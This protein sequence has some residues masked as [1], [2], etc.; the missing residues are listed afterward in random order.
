MNLKAVLIANRGEIAVRI[1]RACRQLGLKAVAVFSQADAGAYWTRLADEAVEIG[2]AA[3]RASYLNIARLIEVAEQVQADAVH[4]GY[5]LL[6]ESPEF[7]EAVRESG[8]VFVGPTP[9][10]I[11]QMGDKVR[12][13]QAAQAA[14]LPVLPGTP[15]AVTAAEARVMAPDIGFP[16][17]VKASFGGGGRG[18]RVVRSASDL[19]EALGQAV[20]EA[21]AA[22]GRGDVYLERYIDRPRHV[23]VQILADTQGRVIHLGDRD[24]STQRRHQKLIEEAPAPHLSPELAQAM[25]GAAVEL[26]RQVGYIGAGT[27]EFLVDRTHGDFHFLEMNTRLQV[28][29]GVTEMVSGVDLVVAQLQIAAGAPLNM[30][31]DDLRLTGA[32]IQARITAEDPWLDFA[33]TPGRIERLVRPDGPWVRTDFGVEAG[34]DV[35]PFYDSMFGKVQAWGADRESARLRLIG[36]LD[37]LAVSGLSHTGPY[38]RALLD[39]PDFIG[40]DHDTGSVERD[41]RADPD[42]RPVRGTEAPGTPDVATPHREVQIPIAGRLATVRVLGRTS[43][44]STAATRT[45]RQRGG[46]GAASA[47]MGSDLRAPMDSVVAAVAV[48]P[49]QAIGRG[50]PVVVVEAMK[51]EVVLS[52]PVDGIVDTVT[53]SPGDPIKSGSILAVFRPTPAEGDSE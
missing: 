14:G 13:R 38:L 20:R 29:H 10:I 21:T 23:E 36:A 5:G 52:A 16:L 40:V 49:G 4:P 26:A 42:R 32:A 39:Q 48:V 35:S 45:A 47:H 37:Q 9:E 3:P 43:P 11:A 17:A 12:A 33:P 30:T 41:W 22:F 53:V 6:S 46:N 2:P 24:C 7:A 51:M 34:D 27:V 15:G 19:D 1:I 25:R 44:A 18:M 31:Q 28:E 50:D 8:R